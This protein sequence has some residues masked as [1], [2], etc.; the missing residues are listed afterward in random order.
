[1]PTGANQKGKRRGRYGTPILTDPK[2]EERYNDE[3][4]GL[5]ARFIAASKLE[6]EAAK[7]SAA[8][9]LARI[10]VY[11]DVLSARVANGTAAVEET[12][13]I[14]TLGKLA[15]ALREEL[16]IDKLKVEGIEF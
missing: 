2:A 7:E 8:W 4:A 6:D 5:A 14:P 15:I 13:K 12:S 3:V 10:D 11:C 16:G 1:M 9:N